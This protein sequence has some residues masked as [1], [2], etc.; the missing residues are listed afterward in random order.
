M[1][2]IPVIRRRRFF[3]T[4]TISPTWR[5]IPADEG[6]LR[7]LVELLEGELL[8][9]ARRSSDPTLV[10]YPDSP[11]WIDTLEVGLRAYSPSV[12][13][14]S[15][16]RF[17]RRAFERRA[18]FLEA[19]SPGLR[20][21]PID[22]ELCAR[23]PD[24]A[25]T[26]ELLWGSV[27]KFLAQGFGFCL[28]AGDELASACYS[29][30]FASGRAE[31]GV[32]TGQAY[33]RQGFARQVTTAFIQECLKRGLQPVWECW[34]ENE[35]SRKLATCLGFEWLEDYPVLFIDLKG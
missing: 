28:M 12:L 10:L 4:S 30:F 14:R 25:A 17:D 16:H 7:G 18:G 26:Y 8:P 35:P 11:D 1:S 24:L 27:Q 6:F 31:I 32:E 33:R 20:L 13:F 29:V 15:L 21:Q 19:L 34:W 3:G 22:A 5:V 2:M 23:F 9:E